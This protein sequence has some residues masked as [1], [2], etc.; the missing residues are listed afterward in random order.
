M[1]QLG[2]GAGF[3]EEAF[4]QPRGIGLGREQLDGY[5]PV[6]A[7]LAG[8]VD[9]PHA[10]TAQLPFQGVAPGDRTLKGDELFVKG[11]SHNLYYGP[12]GLASSDGPHRGR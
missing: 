5:R 7:H 10:A 12:N 6:E 4:A 2:G 1:R 9:H 8:Q 11:K 3:P